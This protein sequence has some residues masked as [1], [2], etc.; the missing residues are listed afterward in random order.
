M[1]LILLLTHFV[2]YL[3]VFDQTYS[4]FFHIIELY[5][6]FLDIYLGSLNKFIHIYFRER[7]KEICSSLTK[8]II[9]KKSYNKWQF[10]KKKKR[11]RLTFLGFWSC[12]VL[13]YVFFVFK[14]VSKV[15][16]FRV[17]FKFKHKFLF[18]NMF[19]QSSFYMFEEIKL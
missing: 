11:P 5:G 3:M 4:P 13:V 15:L 14:A 2:F 7:E 12:V 16:W 19:F 1:T 18:F 6:F 17:W 9:K 10:K 8:M